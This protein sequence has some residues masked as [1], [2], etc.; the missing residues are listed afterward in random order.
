MVASYICVYCYYLLVLKSSETGGIFVYVMTSYMV[1]LFNAG[2]TQQ[3]ERNATLSTAFDPVTIG[4]VNTT[5]PFCFICAESVASFSLNMMML[6]N[7]QG[8]TIDTTINA[9]VI[10][11]WSSLNFDPSRTNN[12]QCVGTGAGSLQYP[13]NFI[14]SRKL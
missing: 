7:T 13:G 6:S 14:P 10:N 9:L 11:D 8:Y 5:L 4:V 1:M 2:A 12:V 3:C